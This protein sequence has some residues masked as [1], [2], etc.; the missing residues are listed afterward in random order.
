M[1]KSEN[2]YATYR[3]SF[4]MSLNQEFLPCIVLSVSS[5]E[6]CISSSRNTLFLH[7][8]FCY[9]LQHAAF[10]EQVLLHHANCERGFRSRSWSEYRDWLALAREA[11]LDVG[12]R[13]EGGEEWLA[14]L[15]FSP[16]DTQVE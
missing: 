11:L 9:D 13:Y 1:R 12:P 5:V 7:F 15:L 2:I 4:E 3:K 16:P 6:R 14:N 10:H 8:L